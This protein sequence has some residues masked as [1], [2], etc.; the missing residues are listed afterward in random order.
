MPKQKQSS[1]I[2]HNG[3]DYN[4]HSSYKFHRKGK[5]QKLIHEFKYNN[6]KEIGEFFAERM[7]TQL[8]QI[9]NAR[10]I[11]PVPIHW[12]KKK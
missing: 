6:Q 12:K 11:I 5:V 4:V 3:K 2:N 1:I 7:S 8:H 9:E 10:Y